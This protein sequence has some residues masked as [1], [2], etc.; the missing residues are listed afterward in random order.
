MTDDL[1]GRITSFVNKCH[2]CTVATASADGQPSA[3]LVFFKNSELDIYFNTG[4]GS[5]KV[6][7]IIDNPRV[8]IAMQAD[9]PVPH[10]DKAIK[11]IQCMGMAIVLPDDDISGVPMTVIARH[12]AF[13]SIKPGE[14]VIVKVVPTKIY[15]IDYA[16]GFR[17][18]DLLEL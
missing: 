18:R 13:N 4:R 2:T 5:E 14:S 16:R 15:L 3:S 12:N 11:G 7:N 9:G 6:N 1:R 8:A 17:H 10:S